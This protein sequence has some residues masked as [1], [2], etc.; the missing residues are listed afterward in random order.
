MGVSWAVVA[1]SSGLRCC[2]G[3]DLPPP[4]HGHAATRP[5]HRVAHLH[6]CVAAASTR[7]LVSKGRGGQGVPQPKK[8]EGLQIITQG[9]LQ[10]TSGSACGFS[11]SP[12]ARGPPCRPSLPSLCPGGVSGRAKEPVCATAPGQRG[13][14]ARGRQGR[15][16]THPAHTK[17][18]VHAACNTAC[19]G[20]PPPTTP[21]HRAS[22]SPPSV[23]HPPHR[24]YHAGAHTPGS[25]ASSQQSAAPPPPRSFHS[26][27]A[28]PLG[29]PPP[30]AR[31]RTSASSR[32][33]STA[34]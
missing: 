6:P 30:P 27:D 3:E 13:E 5:H 24:A 21:H 10:Q 31:W 2:G 32:R 26:P 11:S 34:L 16:H 8:I 23:P 7:L 25:P 14:S 15:E 4:N 9:F 20:W 19:P 1:S 28:R 17:S 33:R 18:G 29:H 12:S 22:R